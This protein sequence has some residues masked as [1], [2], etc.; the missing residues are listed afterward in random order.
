MFTTPSH[1]PRAPLVRVWCRSTAGGTLT[2][3]G[4]NSIP[5][6]ANAGPFEVDFKHALFG[7]HGTGATAA[8]RHDGVSDAFDP[9]ALEPLDVLGPL[10]PEADAP[11]RGSIR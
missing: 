8:V 3:F 2:I 6:V 1:C 9:S 7:A 5:T 10:L 4:G 11:V